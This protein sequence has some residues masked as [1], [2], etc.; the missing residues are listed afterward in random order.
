MNTTR[1]SRRISIAT[2]AVPALIVAAS[3]S[4]AAYA[5]PQKEAAGATAHQTQAAAQRDFRGSRLIGR[6]IRENG[7]TLGTIRDLVI[8]MDT[9]DVRYAIL[10]LRGDIAPGES[11]LY[12]IPTKAISM[13]G[14]N[15]ELTL[16]IPA[17][18]WREKSFTARTWP[19]LHNSGYW[20]EVERLSGYPAVQPAEAYYAFRASELIG[21]QVNNFDGTKLGTL[22]D[23]VVDMNRQNVHYA[24]LDF[25]PG[26]THTGKLFRFPVTAFSFRE[27]NTGAL[28]TSRPLMLDVKPADLKAMKSF[29]AKNWPDL[30][31]PGHLAKTSRY[32][33]ASALKPAKG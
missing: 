7:V 28:E 15:D 17:S 12:A 19:S 29:D 23:I 14:K 16:N 21:K 18:R 33:K 26:A 9:G 8:N 30:N 20:D 24:V 25:S 5:V 1:T 22:R 11:R 10:S 27:A 31:E 2:L 6:E 3:S 32:L 13:R 4:L